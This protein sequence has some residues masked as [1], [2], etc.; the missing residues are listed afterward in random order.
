MTAF[1]APRAA[2]PLP[3]WRVERILYDQGGLLV[4]D[5]PVG[6]PVHG[7]D[8]E[9]KDDCVTRLSAW[10]SQQGRPSELY[11]HQRLDQATSGVLFFLTDASH[12][13]EFARAMEEHSIERRYLAVVER[14][15]E[16]RAQTGRAQ[17]GRAEGAAQKRGGS[18]RSDFVVGGAQAGK[19]AR[20]RGPVTSPPERFFEGT[21]ELHL[22]FERGRAHVVPAHAPGA[23]SAVTH[24]RVI[25]QR[26]SRALCEVTLSTGRPHQIRASLAHLGTPVVGDALYGGAPHE[27]V[28]LHAASISGGPLPR[29]FAAPVP[30]EFAR[31]LL[32]T[33]AS[34][35]A[36]P[37]TAELSRRALDAALLR[38]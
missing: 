9:L 24:V 12:N 22:S 13:A 2:P 18:R 19:S 1:D 10:L 31:A 34:V 7:G 8:E 11:V 21:I 25:E 35:Q 3:L 33:P 20:P 29:P 16:P 6:L 28:L 26:A 36:P 23:K 27:R 32:E 38:A 37:A 30:P 15:A 17:R 5:K 4:V 14:A